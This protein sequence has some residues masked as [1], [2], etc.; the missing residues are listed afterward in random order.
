[1]RFRR[2]VVA[3][4]FATVL[5]GTASASRLGTG[6]SDAGLLP[7]VSVAFAKWKGDGKGWKGGHPGR[8]LGW[9]R[10]H[11]RGWAKKG[12]HRGAYWR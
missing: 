2:L 4:A 9:Q 1:M 10:G 8:H 12:R 6:T 3:A 5:A 7:D 11:H